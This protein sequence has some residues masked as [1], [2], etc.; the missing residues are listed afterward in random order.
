MKA[1]GVIFAAR[2]LPSFNPPRLPRSTA[3]GCY[4]SVTQHPPMDHF[5]A[6]AVI[7]AT[8]FSPVVSKWCQ[9]PLWAA[10]MLLSIASIRRT[11]AVSEKMGESSMADIC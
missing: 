8:P 3:A 2:V 6:A 1:A 7:Y 5:C 10:R 11:Q 9:R 4:S